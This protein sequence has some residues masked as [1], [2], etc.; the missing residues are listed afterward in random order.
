MSG[1]VDIP[2][3]RMAVAAAAAALAFTII[4]KYNQSVSLT[5]KHYW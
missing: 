5:N 1:V 4:Q 2:V 3:G